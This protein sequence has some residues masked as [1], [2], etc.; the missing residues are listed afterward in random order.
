MN[1]SCHVYENESFIIVTWRMNIYWKKSVVLNE[2]ELKKRSIKEYFFY[3]TFFCH[4]CKCDFLL[5]MRLVTHKNECVPCYTYEW[6]SA[7]RATQCMSHLWISECVSSYHTHECVSMSLCCDLCRHAARSC[8]QKSPISLQNSHISPQISPV[9]IPTHDS[10]ILYDMEWLIH[11]M[12]R[13]LFV[14]MSCRIDVRD[15]IYCCYMKW[16]IPVYDMTPSHVWHDAWMHT[17]WLNQIHDMTHSCTWG[18]SFTVKNFSECLAP[19]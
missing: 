5:W 15:V 3:H 19:N 10:F 8:P 6:M 14:Y 17:T 2:V 9:Q 18:D 13:D 4:T 7:S 11:S 16:C 1:A 12:W